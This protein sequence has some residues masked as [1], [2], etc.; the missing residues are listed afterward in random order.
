MIAAQ[1]HL[2]MGSNVAMTRWWASLTLTR[3]TVAVGADVPISLSVPDWEGHSV[4]VGF[5]IGGALCL[6]S[7][8]L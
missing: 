5:P 1:P 3:T 4:L 6:R 8:G 7:A 2:S